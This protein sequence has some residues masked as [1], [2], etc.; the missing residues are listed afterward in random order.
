M[1][2][3]LA[4]YMSLKNVQLNFEVID[5]L[6]T[7]YLI[8]NYKKYECP[9]LQMNVEVSDGMIEISGGIEGGV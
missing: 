9:T 5:Q 6:F 1:A 2:N 8:P 4:K 7:S 3:Y